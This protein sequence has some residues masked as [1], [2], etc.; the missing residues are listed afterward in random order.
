MLPCRLHRARIRK[1]NRESPTLKESKVFD[2]SKRQHLVYFDHQYPWLAAWIRCYLGLSVYACCKAMSAAFNVQL[3]VF[4]LYT[5]RTKTFPC[6][7]DDLLFSLYRWRLGLNP[8]RDC[9][10]FSPPWIDELTLSCIDDDL[11][12]L[13]KSLSKSG[14]IDEENILWNQFSFFYALNPFSIF[15]TYR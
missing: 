6:I 8:G 4:S 7:D 3:D 9:E 11:V 2:L 14:G 10:L 1:R 15:L 5:W 12:S 13:L